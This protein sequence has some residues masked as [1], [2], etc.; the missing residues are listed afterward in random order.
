MVKT[1]SRFPLHLAVIC[2]AKDVVKCLFQHGVDVTQRDF[3]G[4]NVL[5]TLINVS[6]QL[7]CKDHIKSTHMYYL[8]ITLFQEHSVISCLYQDDAKG[9]RPLELAASLGHFQ[10]MNAIFCTPGVYLCKTEIFGF[11][12]LQYFRVTEYEK[13]S[14]RCMDNKPVR[15]HVS[16]LRLLVQLSH[17]SVDML[18]AK[19][20]LLCEPLSTWVLGKFQLNRSFIVLRLMLCLL[21]LIS[22]FILTRPQWFST[23]NEIIMSSADV[24]NLTVNKSVGICVSIPEE[25]NLALIFII[26]FTT[27]SVI[28][29]IYGILNDNTLSQIQRKLTFRNNTRSGFCVVVDFCLSMTMMSYCLL[30]VLL[31]PHT[32]V[33]TIVFHFL[34]FGSILCAVWRLIRWGLAVECVRIYAMTLASWSS[35]VFF[36]VIFFSLVFGA[37][38][39]RLRVLYAPDGLLD[40]L[41]YFDS[42]YQTFLILLNIE[43]IENVETNHPV[44]LKEFHVIGYFSIVVLLFSFLIATMVNTYGSICSNF[45]VYI[46][47]YRLD[48]AFRCQDC[49]PPIIARLYPY[50]LH[51]AFVTQGEEVYIVRLTTPEKYKLS[52]QMPTL[53]FR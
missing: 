31:P 45:G 21:E 8:L 51:K 11:Q 48:T 28:V 26:C 24:T 10:L 44:L 33:A 5:H 12:L 42:L 3:R 37:L 13:F 32:R 9:L 34:Y 25:N 36:I 23:S 49:I 20:T 19:T 14:D 53:H 39:Q 52:G 35:T 22:F 38:F 50:L 27:A 41:S 16:P 46:T 40:P 6:S 29:D 47:M 43:I 15:E 17:C 30:S 18:Q 4:N 1:S 7:P 2:H